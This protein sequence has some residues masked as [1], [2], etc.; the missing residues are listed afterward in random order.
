[1]RVHLKSPGIHIPLIAKDNWASSK[2]NYHDK[3]NNIEY[4]IQ[5]MRTQLIIQ[6]PILMH[7]LRMIK[8]S[9]LLRKMGLFRL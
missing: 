8:A 5:D 7:L 4:P 2:W 6:L 3:E 1:M 9:Y